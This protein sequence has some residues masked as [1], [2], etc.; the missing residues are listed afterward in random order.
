[1]AKLEIERKFLVNEKAFLE[2]LATKTQSLSGNEPWYDPNC[3]HH[4]LVTTISQGYFNDGWRVRVAT[5]ATTKA[6]ITIKGKATD[7]T[8]VARPEYEYEI[9]AQDGTDLLA[10]CTAGKLSK[11]RR[12]VHYAGNLWEV[13]EFVGE[14]LG[15][16]WLA[17][18][19]LTSIDQKFEL[20]PWVGAEVTQDKS[21]SNASLAREGR[22]QK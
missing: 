9:P 12:C 2:D 19:E 4:V 6:W 17:E 20:P 3:G 15:G 5:T 21:F 13:D 22:A 8:R 11:I 16:L 1:M 18:I 14:S 7:K 10:M